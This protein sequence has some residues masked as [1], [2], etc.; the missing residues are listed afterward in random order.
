VA[1]LWHCT[2]IV[3]LL[4][5]RRLR[6]YG[7]AR[8]HA[9]YSYYVDY[10]YTVQYIF[11]SLHTHGTIACLHAHFRRPVPPH[12]Y[13]Y[14]SVYLSSFISFIIVPTQVTYTT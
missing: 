8:F 4:I 2:A 10:V 7:I 6:Y 14:L 12:I 9:S 13:S 1:L 5:L 11:V 3:A